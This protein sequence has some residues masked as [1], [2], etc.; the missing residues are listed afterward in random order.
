V[1][2]TRSREEKGG[3]GYVVW[4]IVKVRL[5]ESAGGK[6]NKEFQI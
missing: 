3:K 6:K 5:K 2:C 4:E 1:G